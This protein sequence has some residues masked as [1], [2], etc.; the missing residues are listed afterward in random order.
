MV[1]NQ[2]R[3]M[4]EY[5]VFFGGGGEGVGPSLWEGGTGVGGWG[6]EPGQ[7]LLPAPS[8]QLLICIISP[9]LPTDFRRRFDAAD[10]DR[11]RR[12]RRRLKHLCEL[13]QPP[14]KKARI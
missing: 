14:E 7:A 13:R 2:Q 11:Q 10:R 6:P 1:T 12:R 3:S 4:P 5:G 8:A 9:A